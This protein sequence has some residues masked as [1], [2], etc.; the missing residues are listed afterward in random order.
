MHVHVRPELKGLKP[1]AP[2]KSTEEV[3]SEYGLE[4]I[5]KLASNENP[6]GTSPIVTEALAA[7]R[8][9][10]IYPDGAAS[11][12]RKEVAEYNGVSEKQLIFAAGLDELIQI[13]SRAMLCQEDNTV[14]AGGTFPQYRHN[15]VIQGAEIREVPLKEGTHDLE[16]M[17]DKV[18]DKT[19]V[20][21]ICNPNN[22][23]GTY[24]SGEEVDVF[25]QTV[26]DHVLV[27]MDEAYFEYVT[28]EDYPQTI[29]LIQ[30]HPNLLILR[31]FSKAFGL[32]AFR[33][34]YGIGAESFVGQLET[35]RL[36]FNTSVLAQ[37]AAI[38]ALHDLD[39][40][41]KSTNL[42]AQELQKF[43]AFCQRHGIDFYPSQANFIYLKVPG[44]DSG[45][46]FQ[47]L[48]E[49]GF[50]VRAFPDGIRITVGT[51]ENN[52]GLFAEIEEMLGVTSKR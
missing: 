51:K 17:A 30:K 8:D 11:V 36:P 43:Y 40:V 12:L 48:L 15:A 16:A 42:N 27:V 5:T 24:V 22:P 23:T 13:V 3:K 44:K 46:V 47:Y 49:K 2:G 20:V 38:A 14:M 32:A 35:A 33:I 26:P 10:A 41:E 25:L 50:V 29:P 34:G 28:A 31:T 1:Y 4:H 52:E 9:F 39:F 37:Q 21:W 7:M 45:E 19:K 6:Y 18:D